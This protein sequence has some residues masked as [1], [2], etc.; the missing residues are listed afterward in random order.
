MNGSAQ[1]F[2]VNEFE[3]YKMSYLKI[4]HLFYHENFIN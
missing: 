3:C 1:N 2:T 4:L